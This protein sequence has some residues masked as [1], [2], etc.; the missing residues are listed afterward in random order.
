MMT[1]PFDAGMDSTNEAM[2]QPIPG[3]IA[4]LAERVA[5]AASRHVAKMTAQHTSAAA[6]TDPAVRAYWELPIIP[7]TRPSRNSTP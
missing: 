5:Q 4:P 1:L 6:G 7:S 3:R 2:I